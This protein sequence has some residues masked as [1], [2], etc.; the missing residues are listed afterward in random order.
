MR[1]LLCLVPPLAVLSTGK[2]GVFL[3]NCILT[4]CLYFPGVIHAVLVVNQYYADKRTDR[5]VS[6]MRSH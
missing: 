3:L 1:Y 6:A 5:I 4:L 2:V